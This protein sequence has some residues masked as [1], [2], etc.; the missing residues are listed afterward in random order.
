MVTQNQEC[1][2]AAK[3]MPGE[4]VLGYESPSDFMFE[5]RVHKVVEDG[6]EHYIAFTP[7][8]AIVWTG[9]TVASAVGA[10]LHGVADLARKGSLNPSNP[11]DKGSPPIQ[12]SIHV[13]SERLLWQ[14]ERRQEKAADLDPDGFP[15]SGENEIACARAV[16]LARDNEIIAA[17]STSIAAMARVKDL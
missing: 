17:L 4:L 3:D 6:A 13:L 15:P 11:H 14:I 1:A 8:R 12:H 2:L 10:M 16:S 7:Y 9:G 5:Y